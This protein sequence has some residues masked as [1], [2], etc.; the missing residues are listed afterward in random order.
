MHHSPRH[1][2]RV[3]AVL[4]LVF[5]VTAAASWAQ[6]RPEPRRLSLSRAA[7]PG[8][9]S[10]ASA[11]GSIRG[12]DY[13]EF[14]VSVRADQVLSVELQSST[15]E[16]YFALDEERNNRLVPFSED[17]N[18]LRTWSGVIPRS[19]TV[20]ITVYLSEYA[21]HRGIVGSFTL[22]VGVRDPAARPTPTPTPSPTPAPSV[23]RVSAGNVNGLRGYGSFST[24]R[25]AQALPGY[26]VRAEFRGSDVVITAR[27][28]GTLRLTFY[29][30]QSAGYLQSVDVTDN[31]A[32]LPGQVRIGMTHRQVIDDF[33]TDNRRWRTSVERV[34]GERYVVVR[35]EGAP[36]VAL[37]FRPSSWGPAPSYFPPP[38]VLD[39]A[40]L[41]RAWWEHP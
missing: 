17:Y 8:A 20:I 21:S 31:D 14:A 41:V 35:L 40:R 24:A 13:A 29:G 3:L 2:T 12:D 30:V 37:C 34:A 22:R 33:R 27:R 26:N 18:E 5:A 39:S 9:F 4:T 10:T 28:D 6:Q 32:V 25:I 15:P 16:M 1:L 19:C 36:N 23:V 11:S 38:Q 7:S